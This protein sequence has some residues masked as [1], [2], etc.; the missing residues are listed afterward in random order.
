MIEAMFEKLKIKD[1]NFKPIEKMP[2][3]S[4]IGC[5]I[6]NG[7]TLLGEIGEI[8]PTVCK[9][10]KINCKVFVAVLN[11]DPIF[12]LTGKTIIFEPISKFP[13]SCFDLT[14]VCDKNLTCGELES[15]IKKSVGS[16]LKS[17]KVFAIYEDKSLGENLKSV[18]FNIA[19]QSQTHTLEKSE[20]DSTMN[21]LIKNLEQIG[22]RLR[23]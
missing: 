22:A 8:H 13:E 3:H 12:K 6:L 2:F 21:D 20:I 11:L 16:I 7:R 9:N 17:C 4:Y 1:V 23:Q 15:K 19:I 18:S 5:E 14:L 10:F